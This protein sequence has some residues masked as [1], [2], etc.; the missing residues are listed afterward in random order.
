MH[1][2]VQLFEYLYQNRQLLNSPTYQCHKVLMICA[3]LVIVQLTMADVL[4]DSKL[5]AV[6]VILVSL[7]AVACCFKKN[8][9]VHID[10]E[11]LKA[12]LRAE[13]QLEREKQV[14]INRDKYREIL[15]EK[16][17]LN[18]MKANTSQLI[19][20]QPLPQSHN[21]EYHIYV[22]DP[23]M[24]G[25]YPSGQ[26]PGSQHPYPALPAAGDENKAAAVSP[27]SKTQ[28]TQ[29]AGTSKGKEQ[30]L[31]QRIKQ[32]EDLEAEVEYEYEQLQAQ[33]EA[34]GQQTEG[35]RILK[36]SKDPSH[37]KLW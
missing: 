7:A 18:S 11:K 9:K 36:K 31:T 8:G 10:E 30:G 26:Y 32:L 27:A 24:A 19:K 14:A 16:A 29:E 1:V 20:P 5:L 4:F 17:R 6:P 35:E 23:P 28:G 3:V 21:I 12:E 13:R 22:V 34:A 25:Y 37:M 15:K 33:V 2:N